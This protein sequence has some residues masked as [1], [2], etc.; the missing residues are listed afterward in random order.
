MLSELRRERNGA[1]ADSMRFYGR[2]CGLNLGV[3][4]PTIRS[5]AEAAPRDYEFAKYLY[6]QDVRE[7]RIAALQLADPERVTTDELGFWADGIINSEIAEYA[8]MKLFSRVG[9]I[10]EILNR[11][12]DGC[13]ELLGYTA[14]MSAARNI[15]ARAESVLP[16]VDRCITALPDSRLIAQGAAAA[17]VALYGRD[18]E[19][20]K[21][22]I[23]SLTGDTA[24]AEYLSE[25]VLWQVE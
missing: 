13:D 18:P 8:A 16:A 3:S 23:G 10:D 21:A 22:F 14:F 20:V 6:K 11:W 15:F 12:A 5:I 19:P 9:Y 24:A 1:V 2:G 17:L 25:E 7:L 4:I